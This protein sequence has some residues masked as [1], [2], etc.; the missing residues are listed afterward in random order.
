MNWIFTITILL[1]LLGGGLLI[2]LIVD[3]NDKKFTKYFLFLLV[4]TGIIITGY[5][6]I[7]HSTNQVWFDNWKGP[8][9]GWQLILTG[10]LLT[11]CSGCLY[12]KNK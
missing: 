11:V 1:I 9:E 4:L 2:V 10:V 7:L 8:A 5:G 12:I 6:I 3:E